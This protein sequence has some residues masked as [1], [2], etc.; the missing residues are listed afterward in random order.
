MNEERIKELRKIIDAASRGPWRAIAD[1]PHTREKKIIEDADGFTLGYVEAYY[2]TPFNE[3]DATFI[4]AARSALPE[5]LNEVERLREILDRIET[6]VETE[7]WFAIER[8][9]VLDM[10]GEA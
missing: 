8:S 6:Y 3:A 1:P 4:A 10:I 9:K 5:A 7:Q 2:D